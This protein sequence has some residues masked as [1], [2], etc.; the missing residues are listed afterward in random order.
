MWWLLTENIVQGLG[1]LLFL[2][3]TKGFDFSDK[4]FKLAPIGGY[5]AIRG[6]QYKQCS[7][8]RDE[9]SRSHMRIV[10][11]ALIAIA[12]VSIFTVVALLLSSDNANQE[13]AIN[14][15]IRGSAVIATVC[16]IALLIVRNK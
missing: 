15:I 10:R 2:I 9:G 7:A 3:S 8:F 6:E 11:Y 1:A 14:D 5:V 16:V 13:A 4:R 12:T